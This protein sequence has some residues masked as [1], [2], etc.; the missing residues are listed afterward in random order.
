[1]PAALIASMCCACR[2]AVVILVVKQC[3]F[4]HLSPGV[5]CSAWLLSMSD[6]FNRPALFFPNMFIL[7]VQFQVLTG[8][9]FSSFFHV[10]I[11]KCSLLGGWGWGERP[12]ASFKGANSVPS[13]DFI[14]ENWATYSQDVLSTFLIYSLTLVLQ[15]GSRQTVQART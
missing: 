12:I 10:S 1:M 6:D 15:N 3:I 14:V 5:Y 11:L 8:C 13:S 7:D 9:F 2:M 4:L